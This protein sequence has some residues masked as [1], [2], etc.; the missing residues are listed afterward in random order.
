MIDEICRRVDAAGIDHSLLNLEITESTIAR[1]VDFMK[2]QVDRFRELGFSVWMDDFG[3]GYSSLDLLQNIKFDLI[4]FD[5][6]FMKQFD[7]GD[8]AKIILTELMKMAIGLGIETIC[9]GVEREEQVQFLREI[10]CSKIQGYYYEK[11]LSL[12]ELIRKFGSGNEIGIENPDEKAYY[13]ALGRIN[14]YD[15]SMIAGKDD[16]NLKHYFDTLPMAIIEVNGDMS[17]FVRTNKA[18]REFLRGAFGY[19][20]PREVVDFSSEPADV[21][22][23]FFEKIQEC[24]RTGNSGIVDENMPDGTVVHTFIRSIA[25][26]PVTGTMAVAIAVLSVTEG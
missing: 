25:A 24:C 18:Y 4:K 7:K 8:E 3:S 1:D 9:E 6:H 26:N 19:E 22:P 23:W 14:L 10:G 13:E 21:G 17:R 16:S 12:D 20:L 15:L 5:M 11:P 2:E